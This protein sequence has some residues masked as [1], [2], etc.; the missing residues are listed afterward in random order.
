MRLYVNGMTGGIDLYSPSSYASGHPADQYA[1]LRDNDPVHWHE[2]PGGPGFWAVTRHED[3]R[4]VSRNAALFSSRPTIMI[5]DGR[6]MD[7]G[8]HTMMLTMD[9]PRHTQYRKLVAPRFLRRAVGL[10]RPEIERLAA[11]IVD[12]VAGRDEF[13][14]V[15][16]VAGLLP[17][18]VIAEMLG[19]PRKDGVELYRLTEAIHAD[20]ASQPDGA[21]Q[22]AAFAMLSYASGVWNDKRARPGDDLASALVAAEVDGHRL[23]E[24][25]FSLFFLLLV[26]AGG[27]TTRNLVAGGMDALFAHPGE[28]QRLTADPGLLPAAIEEMLRWTSPVIYMRRTATAGTELGSRKI[29]AGQKV[30]LYY[31]AANRDPRAFDE[32]ERFDIARTPNDHVAF[33]GGG[34]HFCLGAQVAR[35]EIEAMFLQLLTRLPDLRKAGQTEWLPST[36]ISGPKHIRVRNTRT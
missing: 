3:V 22:A 32:P 21:G 18:Y 33:G 4:A 25:D 9:P 7:L 14:L 31:G 26:D 10:L 11:E 24:T 1:W 30:V 35:V 20:P 19:I 13:D 29:E 36:F 8:D 12:D 15:E 27:D 16:D 28:R 5:D 23:D 6:A 34:Q 2:E 17:S